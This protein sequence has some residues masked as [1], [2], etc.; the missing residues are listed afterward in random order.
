MSSSV[1]GL[2]GSLTLIGGLMGFLLFG[3]LSDMMGRKRLMIICLTGFSIFTVL[4]GFAVG[5]VDF[6]IY[7]F[8]AGIALG[9]VTLDCRVINL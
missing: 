6:A 5:V 3:V 7:R 1:A 8:T 4:C 9:G 2:I